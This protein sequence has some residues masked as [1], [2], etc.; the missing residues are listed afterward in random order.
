MSR[1]QAV[2]LSSYSV[3]ALDLEIAADQARAAALGLNFG[4]GAPRDRDS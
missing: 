4:K 1:R 3:E 2:A